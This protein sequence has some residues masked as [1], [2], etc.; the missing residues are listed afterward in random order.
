[1]EEAPA[2]PVAGAEEPSP[3]LEEMLEELEIPARESGFVQEVTAETP[4]PE[5][6]AAQE[7]EA[8][9][10]TE[11]EPEVAG[12]ALSMD[13]ID[14]EIFEIFMEEAGEELGVIKEQYP[15]WRADTSN[16]T[17]LQTFRRSF[18]TLKG[19]GRMV[20]AHVIGEFAW[21]V[22]NLLNRIMDGTVAPDEEVLEHL[23][24]VIAALPL[25]IEAQEKGVVPQVDVATL[26]ERGFALAEAQKSKAEPEEEEE[27]LAETVEEVESSFVG[28]VEEQPAPAIALPEDLYSIFRVESENHLEILQEF[29]ESCEEN[30]VITPETVR[31]VHTLRGS[32]HLAE[33]EPMAVLAGEMEIYCNHLHQLSHACS[34]EELGLLKEFHATM[35][36][37]LDAIN[38]PGSSLPDW[39]TLVDA[40]RQADHDLPEVVSDLEPVSDSELISEPAAEREIIDLFLEEAAEILEQLDRDLTSWIEEDETGVAEALKRG[41]H[42]IKGGARMAGFLPLGDLARIFHQ[43]ERQNLFNPL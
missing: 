31:A 43:K 19:S 40:I 9:E 28:E 22:E 1:M 29:L 23:D 41:L 8:R 18:H 33:V 21:S 17:A 11:A 12:E 25:L 7:E 38:V 3:P 42:T 39:E 27:P 37:I 13:E 24:Q 20:G 4:S 10:E 5:E 36:A 14:P 34:R 6:Q 2:E 35:V 16:E 15:L 32:S 26:Q 30:C